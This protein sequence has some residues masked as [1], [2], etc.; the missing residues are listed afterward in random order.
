[1]KKTYIASICEVHPSGEIFNS[2]VKGDKDEVLRGVNRYFEDEAEEGHPVPGSS[3]SALSQI[4]GADLSDEYDDRQYRIVVITVDTDTSYEAY[5]KSKMNDYGPGNPK[6]AAFAKTFLEE[7]NHQPFNAE[8]FAEALCR[9][10]PTLQQCFFR[11]VK[12]C[13]MKRAEST[14]MSDE[15]NRASVRMCTDMAG[16]VARYPLPV[17]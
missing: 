12:A 3:F 4:D 15:R 11:L 13:I 9:E 5:T 17:M 14:V 7:L 10:H 8:K 2:I 1:M 16:K 6:E